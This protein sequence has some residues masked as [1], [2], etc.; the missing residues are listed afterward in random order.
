MRGTH[1]S[2][3][4]KFQ[5]K[6]NSNKLSTEQSER[7]TQ[8]VEVEEYNELPMFTQTSEDFKQPFKTDFIV[9]GK[10]LD[11][12]IDTGAAVTIVS[13]Q[14]F[15]T[16]FPEQPLDVAS[17]K[18]KPYT[19]ETMPVLRQFEASYRS[20][21][22]QREQLPLLVVKG[23]GPAEKVISYWLFSLQYSLKVQSHGH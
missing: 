10:D 12:E 8:H 6:S 2:S 14:V 21:K 22:Q 16:M 13:E 23:T 11:I 18:L 20:Y 3:G 17:V 4:N 1:N 15:Q 9:D 5:R 7:N 19:G